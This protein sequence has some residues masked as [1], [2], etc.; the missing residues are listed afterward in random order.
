MS[1]EAILSRIAGGESFSSAELLPYLCLERREQRA[2]VNRLLAEACWR[3]GG[4]ENIRQ[5]KVFIRRAWL[6]SG[7]S[8]EL[9]PLYEQIY[10]ALDDI[11]GIREA[12]KRAGVLRAARGDVAE[13]IRYFDLWMYADLRFRKLDKFEYDFDILDCM[14]R[15]A[16]RYALPP[17][18]PA[19]AREGGKIRVAYLVKGMLELGS[20]IVKISLLYAKHHDRSRVEP[21]FFAPESRRTLLESEAGR[22]HLKLFEEQGCELI[23]APDIRDAGRKLSAVAQMIQDAGAD[24]FVATAALAHFEHYFITTLRPA[25]VVVGFVQGPPEQFSPL[26]LDWG[27]AWPVHPLID[28]PVNCARVVLEQGLPE[29]DKLTPPERRELDVPDDAVVAA[30]A[31]RYVKFQEPEFWRAIIELLDEHP[32]LYYFAMGVG[33]EQIPFLP[34]MLSP[35]VRSRVRF[36]AWRG[37]D[38]LRNLCLADLF[39][40]T[41]PSGGGAVIVDAMA[42]G[43]P[44]VSFKNNYLRLYDQT[45]WSPAE[46]LFDIPEL[47][48]PRGDFAEMKRVVARLIDDEEYRRGLSRLSSEQIRQTRG[49]PERSVRE[50]EDI[51]LRVLEEKISGLAVLDPREAEVEGLTRRRAQTRAVPKWVAWTALQMKRGFRLGERVL[52]RIY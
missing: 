46:E 25:P 36:M 12:Y 23:P 41:F 11:P 39:I 45:D 13:A 37:D 21:L 49:N 3:T 22:E 10:S 8:P 30:T 6:L 19:A 15:L 7:F 31:G 38:Y 43:I 52:D 5:A 51:Y 28:C 17:R 14:D 50:C 4:E 29:R 2:E 48:V 33:E 26:N 34:S 27:I 47:I 42:L 18:P 24:V 20:V 40:D 1:F 44:V 9:L 32:R 16:L 35:R